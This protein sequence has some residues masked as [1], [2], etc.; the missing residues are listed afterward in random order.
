VTDLTLRPLAAGEQRLF[1]SLPDPGL[2]GF[3]AFGDTSTAMWADGQYR[4]EWCWVALRA[5][6]VVARAAWWGGPDDDAPVALDWLDFSDADAATQL[7][8]AAPFRVEYSLKL[9]PGWT[10]TAAVHEAATAR[11]GAAG[12]MSEAWTRMYV[13]ASARMVW[14]PRPGR[15]WTTCTGCPARA[16]G[17]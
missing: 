12:S 16:S 15:R 1:D 2:V 17:G 7:L 3:A 11:I 13:R 14:R 5:D 10:A 8:Q 4:P 6:V 9:P